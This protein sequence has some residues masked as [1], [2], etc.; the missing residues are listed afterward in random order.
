MLVI[1][2]DDAQLVLTDLV[3]VE[4][5]SSLTRSEKLILSYNSYSAS[6]VYLKTSRFNFL[7]L[8]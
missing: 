3:M 2:S 6:T 1:I 5:G 8:T 7:I 4:R